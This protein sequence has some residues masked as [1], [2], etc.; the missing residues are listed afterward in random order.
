M[1]DIQDLVTTIFSRIV[2]LLSSFGLVL[3][4]TMMLGSEGRGYISLSITDAAIVAIF[5]NVF[6]GSS[7]MFYLKK[8]GEAKVFFTALIWIILVSLIGTSIINLIHP[9]NF[10]ILFLLTSVLSFQALV[11]N[12][13]FAKQ[14]FVKGNFFAVII[15][16][17]FFLCLVVIWSQGI[18]FDW[19]LYFKIQIIIWFIISI[20]FVR[21]MKLELATWKELKSICTYGFKNE[22]SYLLQFFSYRLTYF[23][24]YFQLGINDLGVFGVSIIIAESI[25][26][27]SR[28]F[29]SV[30]YS[31]QLH[32]EKEINSIQR[33]NNYFKITFFISLIA[34]LILLLI[35]EVWYT[36]VF[37]D[38]F[39]NIKTILTVLSPG[40]LAVAASNII[41]H[42][43]AASNKQGILIL[44]SSVGLLFTAILTPFFIKE[45]GLWGGALAMSISYLFSSFVLFF[46]YLTKVLKKKTVI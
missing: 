19:E 18:Y 46:A 17:I 5:A 37:S 40:I 45:Y 23:Y 4:S 13:L 21:P 2:A 1:R 35:P 7:A 34:L 10:L 32:D 11:Y 12:Q 27:I 44:K 42:F 39:S 28:S 25:W 31:K 9:V 22:L 36:F 26:V 3:L 30:S 14:Q 15:Q 41:G 43:F 29:S 24:I 20:L 38:E 8:I 16:V 33:T 6:A